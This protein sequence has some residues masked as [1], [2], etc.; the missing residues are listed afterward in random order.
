MSLEK[1][2]ATHSG[3]ETEQEEVAQRPK[4]Q[5]EEMLELLG[6]RSE[7][8]REQQDREAAEPK[9]SEPAATENDQETVFV[10]NP[11]RFKIR[12]GEGEKG[13]EKSLDG[14][15]NELRSSKGRLRA[16]AERERTL[17]SQLEE[18]NRKLQS[19]LDAQAA[20]GT[21]E[22]DADMDEVLGQATD[23]LIEGDVDLAKEALKKVLGK[24]RKSA[25]TPEQSFDEGSIVGRVKQEL[26][27]ERRQTEAKGTWDAFVQ[28]HPEFDAVGED[29]NGDPVFGEERKYGDYIYLRDYAGKVK[30]GELSYREAL[31]QTAEAVSRAFSGRGEAADP[32]KS[33]LQMRQERKKKIE[34]LPVASGTRAAASESQSE[35]S[36]SDVI[37]EM[38][39]ARGLPV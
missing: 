39:K 19:Q 37:M 5:R 2:A 10:D 26:D 29:D 23:A 7:E 27:Q 24:G 33:D 12:V 28:D 36:H 31:N 15:L 20:L 34:Q 3:A 25:A 1:D 6:E 21:D 32:G 17:Q 22:D 35:Q 38:R 8:Q 4:S 16:S 13:E 14:V 30:S 11:S 18:A 9:R